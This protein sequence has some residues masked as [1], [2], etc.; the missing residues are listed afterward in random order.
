[1]GHIHVGYDKPNDLTNL[2]LSKA[3]DLFLA[4]P[5]VI[6]DL[7]VERRALY[8]KAGAMRMKPFGMEMRTLSNFWIFN[9]K[10]ID[11]VY[12]NTL[13]A[14]D[15][16][17]IGGIIT[18]PEEIVEC[19]NTCNKEMA[20]EIIEDYKIKMPVLQNNTMIYEPA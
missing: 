2:E 1:M 12:E 7:D 17:N 19:I 14:I 16:V 15:F 10:L 11:W 3:M 4:I 5:S 6:L 20:L 9:D 13:A 18:N 8:G